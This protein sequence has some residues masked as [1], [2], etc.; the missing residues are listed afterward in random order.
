MKEGMYV[1]NESLFI[2]VRNLDRFKELIE[3]AKKQA[4]E[5]EETIFELSNYDLNI[6]FCNKKDGQ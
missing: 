3:R 4:D 1:S 6:S 2:S 5:L